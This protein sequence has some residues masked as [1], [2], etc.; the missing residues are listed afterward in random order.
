MRGV[1]GGGW[2]A[3]CLDER[4]WVLMVVEVDEICEIRGQIQYFSGSVKQAAH[5]AGSHLNCKD[6]TKIK[7]EDKAQSCKTRPFVSYHQSIEFTTPVYRM[8]SSMSYQ[9]TS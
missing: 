3:L 9:S 6:G 5:Y 1:L 4:P 7:A 2:G 8:V